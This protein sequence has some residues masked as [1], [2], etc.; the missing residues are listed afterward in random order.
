MIKEL[1][2]AGVFVSPML[3]YLAVALLLTGLLR[4]ILRRIG[5]YRWVWHPPLFDLSLLVM[6]LTGL[7]VWTM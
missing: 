4:V 7:V 6:V 5:A 3:G 1:D 2:F